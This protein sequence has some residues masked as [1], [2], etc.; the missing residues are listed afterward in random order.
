MASRNRLASGVPM[1]AMYI[2]Y[3][4]VKSIKSTYRIE[5]KAGGID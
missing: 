3:R 5:R 4:F 1:D 2:D